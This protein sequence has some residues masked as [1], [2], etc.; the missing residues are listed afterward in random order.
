MKAIYQNLRA[1]K[2][3]YKLL[4]VCL[5]FPIFSIN[6]LA[7][8]DATVHLAWKIAPTDSIVYKTLMD[9]ID[10]VK[11]TEGLHPAMVFLVDSIKT[12]RKA[13]QVA[14]KDSTKNLFT[15]EG[16]EKPVLF[17]KL[18]TAKPDVIDVRMYSVK[19][20]KAVAADKK[21]IEETF[22]EREKKAIARGDTINK[23]E[24]RKDIESMYPV[25]SKMLRGAVFA[26]G[27]IRSFY[28]PS[29]QKNLLALFFEL[30]QKGI[31]VGDTWDL[32]VQFI[33]MNLAECDS[34]FKKHLVTLKELK[35]QGRDTI[36]VLAYDFVEYARGNFGG[37]VK[38]N[39]VYKGIAEFSLNKGRWVKY[40]GIMSLM[41][42]GG[43]ADIFGTYM[44]SSQLFSLQKEQ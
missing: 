12:V 17:A 11:N 23:A 25:E 21:V 33:T 20:K 7:Q 1:S 41:M 37:T 30:P 16:F 27:G 39:I 22:E 28:M 10:S 15:M 3:L 26:N 13:Q 24:V 35:T 4:L 19:S 40:D 31:K 2:C 5:L 34:S 8:T 36:A 42:Q 44:G 43:L 9:D 6:L 18:T 29:G 38:T 14:L 32:D